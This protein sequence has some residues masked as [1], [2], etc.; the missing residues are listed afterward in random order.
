MTFAIDV[1]G[2]LLVLDS[3]P[4]QQEEE[5][6]TALAAV[7]RR[8]IQRTVRYFMAMAYSLVV[9]QNSIGC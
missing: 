1:R 2:S 8:C 3:Y 4:C 9:A 7:L 5:G 6:E